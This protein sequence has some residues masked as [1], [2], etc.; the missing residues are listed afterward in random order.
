MT[1]F[2]FL[3]SMVV[4]MALLPLLAR[5]APVLKL[6]DAPAERKV[7]A[8][9]IP[10]VGGIA[11]AVGAVAGLSAN[12]VAFDRGSAAFLAGAALIFCFGVVDDRYDLDY[13]LKLFGQVLASVVFVVVGGIRVETLDIWRTFD[14]P[15]ILAIALTLF[16]MIGVTNAVNLSDGLDGLAGGMAFLCLSALTWLS[17][18][19]GD[20]TG[21][22][23]AAAVGG[24]VVGFLRFNTFPASV[25]MGDA[26]SQL[27]GFAIGGLSLLATRSGIVKFSATLPVLLLGMPILD[28]LQV[29]AGRLMRGRSPFHADKTH[30]HHRLLQLGLPHHAAV[31]VIYALQ[32]LLLCAAY[33]VRFESDGLILLIFAVY[34]AAL[35]GA[36]YALEVRRQRH[37]GGRL[38]LAATDVHE[39]G[40]RAA[41]LRRFARSSAIAFICVYAGLVIVDARDSGPDLGWA[42][43][44]LILLMTACVVWAPR[45]RLVIFEN[46]LFYAVAAAFVFVD[47]ATSADVLIQHAKLV[48]IVATALATVIALRSGIAGRFVVSPL[49]LLVLFMTLGLPNLPGLAEFAGIEPLAVAK[50]VV[51]LYAEEMLLTASDA[52]PRAARGVALLFLGLLAVV[53]HGAF[54]P[55]P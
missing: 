47:S 10:R 42:L 34:S 48:T 44:A 9:P 41:L 12:G 14:L 26:G 49:D 23:L 25:F 43:P 39:A 1:I 20:R 38:I 32:V 45:D 30:L 19:T 13:R 55:R 31:A 2:P 16:Y 7:H 29:M 4:A 28:T 22:V 5:M 35:L 8:V 51:L 3:I 53:L 17:Y 27:L 40:H 6:V 46:G 54:W 52:E 18:T 11:M 24:A 36:L 37:H 50:I 21:L 15:A 33:L